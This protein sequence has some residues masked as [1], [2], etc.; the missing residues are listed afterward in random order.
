MHLADQNRAHQLMVGLA[1]KCAMG[2]EPDI[3]R[4]CVSLQRTG[5]DDACAAEEDVDG[6]HDDADRDRRR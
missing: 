5:E 2:I 4:Q 6:D 3:R 1:E